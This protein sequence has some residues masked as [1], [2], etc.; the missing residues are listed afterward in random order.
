MVA[1]IPS[2][3]LLKITLVLLRSWRIRWLQA[4]FE[5]LENC[6]QKAEFYSRK[7]NHAQGGM[8]GS[9]YPSNCRETSIAIASLQFSRTTL[10]KMFGE[11]VVP[12]HFKFCIIVP[13]ILNWFLK[14]SGFWL[15]TRRSFVINYTIVWSHLKNVTGVINSQE[16]LLK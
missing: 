5:S 14:D 3:S 16:G 7:K 10:L 2:V 12:G 4:V 6:L 1:F 8:M 15:L 13:S 9:S 11:D